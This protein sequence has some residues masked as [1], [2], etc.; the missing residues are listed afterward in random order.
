M[1]L[2]LVVDGATGFAEFIRVAR[3]HFHEREPLSVPD[4]QVDLAVAGRRAVIACDH[5]TAVAP[6]E[7]V[8]QVFADAAMVVAVG[9]APQ[10]I[11][12]AVN[13]AEHGLFNDFEFELHHLAADDIAE[14]ILPEF[15][16]AAK[17]VHQEF[18]SQPPPEGQ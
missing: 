11:G 14:V 8:R 6:Q 3:L 18:E 12:S 13:Q 5:S 7:A 4:H 15:P 16:V 17:M 1:F 10:G 9:S 2:L